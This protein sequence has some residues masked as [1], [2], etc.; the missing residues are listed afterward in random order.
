M[1]TD[2]DGRCPQGGEVGIATGIPT[3]EA[4]AARP[5]TATG[6]YGAYCTVC[7]TLV[8]HVDGGE[9]MDAASDHL[10]GQAKAP[11]N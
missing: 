7:G 4:V 6:G 11:G 8:E 3:A 1:T 5:P 9:A 10:E 2:D